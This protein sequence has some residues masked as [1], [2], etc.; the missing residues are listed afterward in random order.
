MIREIRSKYY[1][2]NDRRID[3]VREV[4]TKTV[5]MAARIGYAFG[6]HIMS[7][8]HCGKIDA[9]KFLR[10][11]CPGV[12]LKTSKDLVEIF[13]EAAEESRQDLICF[14]SELESELSN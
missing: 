14:I 12:G 3:A 13:S 5:L 4:D 2:V 8:V 10:S 6:P 11:V 7:T 9:I 1:G